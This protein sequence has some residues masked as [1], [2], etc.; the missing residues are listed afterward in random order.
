[1]PKDSELIRAAQARELWALEQVYYR[2][3]PTVWRYVYWRT[4]GRRQA[5]EDIVSETFLAAIR[6]LARLDPQ[7]G[8]LAAW[9]TGIARHKLGDYRREQRR[10]GGSADSDQL[11][12]V[13]A[14]STLDTSQIVEAA[15]TRKLVIEVMNQLPDEHRLVLEWKYLDRLAVAEIGGRLGRTPKAVESMLYRARRSFRS[16]F[17]LA[18]GQ[19]RMTPEGVQRL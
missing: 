6:Q 1:L 9:L 5:T 11:V 8:S 2:Y 10:A 14:T 17:A 13:M 4:G 19:G 7:G 12:E 15:E 3:L 16:L 18:R